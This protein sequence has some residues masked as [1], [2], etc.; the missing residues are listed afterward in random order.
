[1]TTITASHRP[2]AG[3]NH[4]RCRSSVA[5]AMLKHSRYAAR[6]AQIAPSKTAAPSLRP[7]QWLSHGLFHRPARRSQGPPGGQIAIDGN[8]HAA[9]RGFLPWRLSDAGPQCQLTHREWAGIRNPSQLP[10]DQGRSRAAAWRPKADRSRSTRKGAFQ[11][12]GSGS[13]RWSGRSRQASRT[14][15]SICGRPA[16]GKGK[17]GGRCGA[18]S[19]A[20]IC[21]AFD[22]AEDSRRPV[23]EFA[24]RV[25][26]TWACSKHSGTELVVPAP[27]RRLLCHT[28]LPLTPTPSNRRQPAEAV[29]VGAL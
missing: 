15:R 20:A 3:G 12:L 11:L 1:M 8:P 17:H 13:P 9:H 5:A 10:T 16:P 28:L 23:W 21:P 22:A 18:W 4:F 25:Q 2:P 24:D 19:D 27:S 26:I 7:L 6:H 14:A 29:T